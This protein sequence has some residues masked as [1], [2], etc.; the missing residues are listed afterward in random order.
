MALWDAVWEAGQ[1]HH[2]RPGAPN[3]IER[4]ET[5]L[6]S[7]GSDMTQEDSVLECA[8]ERYLHLD[9]PVPYMAK[10]AIKKQLEQG[11]KRR[12]SN[13]MIESSPLPPLRGLWDVFCDGQLVG[14]VSS[15]AYS[16]KYEAN[17]AF[18]MLS[19]EVSNA[20]SQLTLMVDGQEYPATVKDD[21]WKS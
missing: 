7:Y 11:V 8:F 1:K 19:Q 10:D 15:C 2:I 3:L 12:L 4:L 17:L 6:K 21:R 13:L 16:P 5:G 20:G 18:A 9:K 14:Q